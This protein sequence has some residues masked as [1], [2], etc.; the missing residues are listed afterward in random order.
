MKVEEIMTK[1]FKYVEIPGTRSDVLEIIKK[2]DVTGMPVL[3]KGTRKV[4]GIITRTDLMNNLEEDQIAMIMTRDI[5]TISPDASVEEA[6]RLILEHNIRYLPV[7][8]DDE[9]IGLVTIADIVWKTIARMN[10]DKPIKEYTLRKITCLWDKTPVSIA[11]IIMRLAGVDVAPALNDDGELSGVITIGD[12]L[13]KG[14]VVLQTKTSN[15]QATGEGTDWSWDSMSILYITKKLLKLP[16]EPIKEIMPTHVIT[17]VE[18]STV[19]ECAGKMR[20][21]DIDHLPVENAK[22]ELVGMIRDRDLLKAYL[23]EQ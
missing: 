11:F 2:Y 21:Y 17:I 10:I 15:M 12:I 5:I 4:A 1:D 23:D 16:N 7:V 3:K 6:A 13:T 9:I 19:S 14:E 22:G 18:Q 20:K 8:K